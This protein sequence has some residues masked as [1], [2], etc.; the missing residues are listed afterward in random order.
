MRPCVR[1][2]LRRL[3]EILLLAVALALA[4]CGREV[5]S[6][7]QP[8]PSPSSVVAD[9]SARDIVARLLEAREGAG[10]G[11]HLPGLD[12][13]TS[14]PQETIGEELQSGQ[15]QLAF[16]LGDPPPGFWAAQLGWEGI[17]V[18]VHSGNSVRSIR[19]KQLRDVF[20]GTVT[21][22]SGLGSEAG[23]IHLV[24]QEQGSPLRLAFDQEVLG[25]SQVSS[26]ALL[27]PDS[28]AVAQTVRQDPLAIGYIAC[29]DW[30]SG[31]SAL[32]L[33]GVAPGGGAIQKGQYPLRIPVLA[34][35]RHQPQAPWD[36]FLA[37]AQGGQ[38]QQAFRGLCQP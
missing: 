8:T 12:A 35:A 7:V 9:P 4:S 37:W 16:E 14:V 26:E 18:V 11:S 27:A 10:T 13:I 28:W 24:S 36:T 25:S 15:A 19:L 38:G 5:A 29:T 31:L 21:S 22:W 20:G 33:E 3:P 2:C 1:S 30:T 32:A 23:A 6:Q 17:L 34:V